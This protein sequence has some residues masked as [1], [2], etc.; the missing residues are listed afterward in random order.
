MV[1]FTFCSLSSDGAH[2]CCRSFSATGSSMGPSSTTASLPFSSYSFL[3]G[4]SF[5]CHT[6]GQPQ[7]CNT[8]QAAEQAMHSE[9][10]LLTAAEVRNSCT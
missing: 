9:E 1:Q 3:P 8:S 4:T 10:P 6:R 2:F 7:H 5:F